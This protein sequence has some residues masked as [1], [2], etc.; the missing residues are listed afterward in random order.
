MNELEVLWARARLTSP[1]QASSTLRRLTTSR[2]GGSALGGDSRSASGAETDIAAASATS[3]SDRPGPRTESRKT[4]STGN[5]ATTRKPAIATTPATAFPWVNRTCLPSRS[6]GA[7]HARHKPISGM[8]N[9][10][11]SPPTAISANRPPAASRPM[12]FRGRRRRPRPSASRATMCGV[13][14]LVLD[15]E[16]TSSGFPSTIASDV[17]R[18]PGSPVPDQ[19]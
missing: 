18:S 11:L 19:T 10:T 1:V 13:T 16:R 12:V 17:S 5:S 7:A 2:A 6:G 9:R 14:V 4:V 8:A 3:N 15:M